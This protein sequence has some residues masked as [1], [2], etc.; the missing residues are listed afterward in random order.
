MIKLLIRSAL[1][2]FL[3]TVVCGASPSSRP[4]VIFVLS[5]DQ[6]WWDY[7]FMYRESIE[8]AAID[9]D[10]SIYQVARTPAIDRLADEGLT[11]LNGY[12][13]PLCRPSL[14]AII[15]G[16]FPHQNRVSGNDFVGKVDDTLA[17]ERILLDQSIARTLAKRLGYRSYQTGKWWGG[18]HSLGGFTEGDTQNSIDPRTKPRQY[19]G[20]RPGYANQGRHGDWGL[21]I[22]RVDYVTDNPNPPHPI[23]YP[24]TIVPMTDFIDDC[25]AHEDPFFIWYA[26]FLPH[27]PFDPPRGLLDE[28]DPRVEEE[29]EAED[30]VAS[31]YA[32][33]E[34]FDGGVGA[35]LDH[36]EEV[37]VAD[38][39][40][41]VFICD[42]GWITRQDNGRRA[43]R[44]KR[45]PYDAGARTPII[46]RW[47]AQ[48][49]LGGDI[50]PQ[51]I[52]QPVSVID[53][54]P[55]AL[56]AVGLEPSLEQRGLNLMDL[57]AVNSR[58]EIYCDIY[59]HDMVSLEN[60]VSS[61]FARFVVKDGW[62]LIDF[63]DSP[64]ELYH[65]YDTATNE[66]IDPFETNDLAI[67]EEQKRLEL[68]ALITEWYDE[69]KDQVW[70][71]SVSQTLGSDVIAIPDELG[72][73]FTIG[74]N[75]FLTGISLPFE[76]AT[77]AHAI[78]LELR[79]LDA[80]DA[81]LGELLASV[82]INPDPI[83]QEG[84][85]WCLFQFE[86]PISVRAG[87]Q[88]GFLIRSSS[89]PHVGFNIPFNRTGG[90]PG[91]AMYY[92]DNID[93]LAWDVASFDL[94]FQVFTSI[95]NQRPAAVI[96]YANHSA[97]IAA[98]MGVRGQGVDI[99]ASDDLGLESWTR[100]ATDPNLDGLV[101]FEES[102]AERRFYRLGIVSIGSV[103]SLADPAEEAESGVLFEEFFDGDG[104][105][106]TSQQ[107]SVT[108]DNLSWIGPS[109]DTILDSGNLNGEG[110]VTAYLPFSPSSGFIYTLEGTIVQ[111]E[112]DEDQWL[113]FGFA[114]QNPPIN[115]AQSSSGLVWA[116]TRNTSGND[117][118]VLHTNPSGGT[119]ATQRGDFV[120]GAATIEMQII[121]DT[122]QGPGSWTYHWLV[123]GQFRLRDVALPSSFEE[124][125][126][127]IAISKRVGS[128]SN[129]FG[130][131]RLSRQ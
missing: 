15:T 111:S 47:P 42:N 124:S 80:S 72:Q 13:V 17:D 31:Y 99:E 20:S 7:S 105:N 4:N 131:L 130:L 66:P 97:R 95:Y 52:R 82:T 59:D 12:T 121:L 50:E 118:Q 64:A 88:L 107:P 3:V 78:A 86:R 73:S 45:S 55:T 103:F 14:Q 70:S 30:H 128:T 24:N 60:P 101:V 69:P 125:I 108:T 53:M 122:T 18:H 89:L 44:S 87:D 77:P 23:N 21:M 9:S 104:A 39:T 34:R 62:K 81:P 36:L 37:G 22:G 48:I 6:A 123:N 8:G 91:G 10:S 63:E 112:I 84:L 57:A 35:L 117:D 11:F 110:G 106:L 5:D 120:T 29:N 75:G 41:I 68:G 67:S 90:Y 28:Y 58:E 98:D 119:G 32:N 25:V 96:T 33:I 43:A 129:R 27:N 74:E 54:V 93:G 56:A 83:Y 71:A 26:P 16:T 85:R 65:L 113:S 94:A 109:S 19:T 51:I 116:L 79:H 100:V 102:A 1:A 127:S 38:N 40:L 2:T 76:Q 46:V 49:K 61:I 114:L 92:S 115:S 126:G